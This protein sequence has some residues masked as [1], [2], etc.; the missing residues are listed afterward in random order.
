VPS[1]YTVN[2]PMPTGVSPNMVTVCLNSPGPI[3]DGSGNMI[4]DPNYDTRYSQFCYTFQYWPGRTTYLDTPVIP[5]AAHAGPDKFPLD[6]E[7]LDETPRIA[8][9]NGPSGGPF[10]DALATSGAVVELTS[11]GD[12]V[13]RNPWF[14]PDVSGS[15]KTEL[16]DF[17][18]GSRDGP[19]P[20]RGEVLVDG[21][22]LPNSDITIWNNTTIRFRAD[23]LTAGSHQVVVMRRNGQVSPVGITVEVGDPATV[24][25]VGI[26]GVTIQETID[27]ATKGDLVLV[28]TG[29]YQETVILYKE[30]K[31]QGYGE[32]TVISAI[33]NTADTRIEWHERLVT[34]EGLLEVEVLPGQLLPSEADL[35]LGTAVFERGFTSFQGAPIFVMTTSTEFDG[36]DGAHGRIDGFTLS[37]SDGGGGV[38]VNGFVRDL[39][40]SNNRIVNNAGNFGGGIRIGVSNLR[41][42]G[43][44]LPVGSENG[45]IHI[46]HNHIA[47][48][49]SQGGPGG[50]ALNAGSDNYLVENNNICGNFTSRDG[51]GVGHFGLSEG[52]VIRS[53]E[54]VF[55]EAWNGTTT[56]AGGGIFVSGEVAS[57]GATV[58]T[59]SG[60]LT[61]D[62]N[63]IM[64][65]AAGTGNGGGISLSRVDGTNLPMAHKI[66][67]TNNIIVKNVTGLAGAVAFGDALDVELIHNTIVNNVSTASAAAAF[68]NGNEVDSV[69]L[70]AGVV[71]FDH[72]AALA[73]IVGSGFSNPTTLS[74]NIAYNN[75]SFFFSWIPFAGAPFGV[76]GTLVPGAAHVNYEAEFEDFWAQGANAL[77]P[78]TSVVRPGGGG[79]AGNIDGDVPLTGGFVAPCANNSVDPLNRFIE[80]T[81]PPQAALVIDEG[82][83]FLDV[84]FGPLTQDQSVLDST[85]DYHLMPGSAASDIGMPVLAVT[86]DFDSDMRSTTTPDAGADETSGAGLLSADFDVDGISNPLDN[87]VVVGNSDQRDPG[88]DGFGAICDPDL[89]GDLITNFGDFAGFV[90][91]FFGAYVADADFNGDAVINFGDLGVMAS[92]FGG[93]PGP[94]GVVR[95]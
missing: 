18:F 58:T 39:E 95:D 45:G 65:N 17:G 71:A 60:S 61:I 23:T 88:G 91:A 15:S 41:T 30:I 76:Q 90:N 40:I 82:G 92:G 38:G 8:E 10:V 24:K 11:L 16:R 51:A 1:T 47:E 80:V 22:I 12:A 2:A 87:C 49:G 9:V 25:R 6:C 74:N 72:S 13:V 54:I 52:G 48:N 63:L 64:A 75:A 68:V 73:V 32:S 89:N 66:T 50:I 4:I 29:F 42:D 78:V 34:L 26:D 85:C 83:N 28:P 79:L 5:I 70:A 14:D 94:S 46:H 77:S 35:T 37:G 44:G 20:D 21:V 33:Q 43:T 7:P 86:D 93:P 57:A 19:G 36:S 56:G 55:N 53:N 59:G 81:T 3:D 62:K 84:A 27:N 67:I 69:P 31:L